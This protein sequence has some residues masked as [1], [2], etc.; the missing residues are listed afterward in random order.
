MEAL[1]TSQ[2]IVR[3]NL[4]FPVMLSILVLIAT[5][6]CLAQ[7]STASVS[8]TVRDPSGAVIT[9]AKIV[10]RNIQTSVENSTVSNAAGVYSIFNITPGQYTIKASAS[11]FGAK[12]VTSFTLTVG[13]IATI[14][15]SLAVGAQEQT[16]TVQSASP[17]L[18][19]SNASL[20]TVISEKEVDD[21]PLN[22]RN[23]T[24]LLSLTP[25]VSPVSTGQNANE[26][27]A[28]MGGGWMVAAAIGSDVVF[29]S[30]N[31]Q[32]NRSNFFLVDGMDDFGEFI[33]SYAVPPIVDAIQE[34][35]VVSHTDSA[36]YG[37]VTG[38]VINVTS[39]SGTNKLH[40]SAWEYARNKIFDARTYFLPTGVAKT[41]YSQNQFGGSI[42][43]PV[44]VPHYNGMDKS[45]FFFAYQGY[46][47]SEISNN[48][49]HVPTSDE[50][51]GNLSSWP[52]QIYNPFSFRPDPSNPGQF[53]GDPFT[54]NQ[55][56]PGLIQ[57][58]LVDYAKFA[59][60]TPG[61]AF[62]SS[63]DNALDTTPISQVQNE[64]NIRIDQKIGQNDSAF[65]RYSA[66]NSTVTESAGLPGDPEKVPIPSRDWGISYVHV[67]TP[68]L[69]LQGQFSH[70][71][72]YMDS[73]YFFTAPSTDIT[74]ELA[75]APTIS[76]WVSVP[77]KAVLPSMTIS[78]YSFN[79][80]EYA[81]TNTA[82]DDWNY[83]GSLEKTVKTHTLHFGG[84]FTKMNNAATTAFP[85]IGFGAQNTADP[86][87]ADT[88]NQGSALASYLLG[89]PSFYYMVNS[90]VATRFGGIGS[91]YGQDSWK[92][93]PT[94]TLNFGLRYDYTLF[95]PFGKDS[96]NAAHGGP[97]IGDYDYSNGTYVLQALPQ[98]CNV[99]NVAPC[100]PGDGTLPDHVVV[101][102]TGK[103][104][105]NDYQ[106][107]G[108]RVGFAYQLGS[109]TAFKGAIG[110]VYDNWAGINQMTQNVSST[111][112][113][114]GIFSSPADLNLPSS[115]SATPTITATN[116]L[117]NATF[118][119]APTPFT[120]SGNFY[121]PQ[122]RAPLSMQWNVGV[123]RQLN[124]N[125]ALTVEYVG[126]ASQRLDYGGNVNAALTPG[127]GDP[128]SR[129]LYPYMPITPY[130][131]PIG[132][133][134]YNAGQFA[135]ERRYAD[136]FSYSVAYTWSK[137]IDTGADGW[138][139]TEGGTAQDAYCISCFGSRSVA[140][141]D[142]TNMLSV[143]TLYQLPFGRGKRFSTGNRALDYVVG[144]WQSNN[145][146]I[147]HTGTP[148]TPLISSD[149]ANVGGN[150]ESLDIV[151]DP[152]LSHRSPSE[153]FNTDAYAVPAGYTYGTAGR[154][155][156]RG[157]DFWEW[158]TSIFRLIELSN[159]RQFE[160]RAEAFNVL[161]N[162]VL[163][164]PINDYNTGPQFG[165][166]NTTT[167]LAR[168]IQLAL[169]FRF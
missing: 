28:S 20:G 80:G 105:K 74:G 31:G 18:E 82:T 151:G 125:T 157:P 163:G 160:F 136:D 6:Q 1:R 2:S 129:A 95:P 45:F 12:E 41:P 143:D 93:T 138:W 152:H 39:K 122:R 24:Q 141:Y 23:F 164:Q 112:P 110:V 13:Q 54:G 58:N 14:D 153:W 115:T 60:P 61:P 35:K 9:K 33:S 79:P 76:N 78:G 107:F 149:I 130:D 127:P 69:V 29:P 144:G 142:A 132:R 146:F 131:R 51:S 165:T 116:P 22:G 25:G 65:F 8:G 68:S 21:I 83:S 57:Q 40:G 161:N 119:P 81:N 162:V 167:N 158:D 89:I 87:P 48:P 147:A 71:T 117:G 150:Q 111:W 59:Y 43:G 166:I 97:Y 3:K 148:F 27:A 37:G 62:D 47:F 124:S 75:L 70:T 114:V 72:M 50:L 139:G 66:Q 34:F 140:G 7:S 77:N 104:A 135:F 133:S 38:G 137:T 108:P 30:V 100:I 145:I 64:W 134:S 86:N 91:A 113:D 120:Q 52:T 46:R 126:M 121:Q 16:V 55:I 36:E 90:E 15:F 67:F 88:V 96:L 49:L 169:K 123:Q 118:L 17:Q 26:G 128:Q 56:T 156:L 84:G 159:E 155:S 4:L 99:T 92:V 94:L 44:V 102:T 154:N 109:K 63:G 85:D 10:L 106:D 53:I 32:T 19:V 11:G 73:S 42:G 101:S 5:G 98:A 168:Q 103:I